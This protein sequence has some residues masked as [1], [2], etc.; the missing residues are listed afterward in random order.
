MALQLSPQNI[1]VDVNV[2]VDADADA[3]ADEQ[4]NHFSG[5]TWQIIA[6]YR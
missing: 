4:S 3:D 1:G 5:P 2:N 6:L